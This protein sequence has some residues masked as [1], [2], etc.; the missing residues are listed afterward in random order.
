VRLKIE[1]SNILRDLIAKKTFKGDVYENIRTVVVS[2]NARTFLRSCPQSR[3]CSTEWLYPC[4]P[5]S[6]YFNEMYSRR[7]YR[8]YLQKLL[9]PPLKF[10]TSHCGKV[11]I[12]T[13]KLFGDN[14]HEHRSSEP[15]FPVQ[16]PSNSNDSKF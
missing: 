13:C 5:N 7:S 12:I 3:Q 9:E 10:V 4:W 2:P 15:T 1:G 11:L 14:Q 8:R 16:G 6:R